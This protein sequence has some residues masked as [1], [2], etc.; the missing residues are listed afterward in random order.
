MDKVKSIISKSNPKIKQVLKLYS[1]RERDKKKLFIIEGYRPTAQAIFS[2]CT[3]LWLFVCPEFF[4]GENEK[5]LIKKAEEKGTEI[6]ICSKMVFEKISY[7]DRPDGILAIAHSFYYDLKDLEQL[8]QEKENC[9]LC[10]VEHV[11]KPGNLGT[12]LRSCDA[13]NVDAVIICDECTDVFNPNV[14][15]ASIG[16][17]FT[18]YIVNT[19]SEKC[20][21]FLKQ[22]KINILAT[23]PDAKEIFTQVDL[24]QSTAIAVGSEQYGLSDL[25]MKKSDIVVK[26]PMHGK[27]DSLNVATATTLV[28]YEVLRQRYKY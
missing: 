23:S 10:V 28:L 26:I 21:E 25:W 11:E 17:L 3:L 9:I 20:L 18:N 19:S 13:T 4:L 27:V 6:F 16:T 1:K 12:I 24:K 8:L 2:K 15:R 22:K 5:D 14:V 7:R